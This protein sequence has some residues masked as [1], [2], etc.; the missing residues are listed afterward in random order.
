MKRNTDWEDLR[1][2][3]AV[4]KAGGLAGAAEKTGVSAA[5]LG[6]RV[7]ALE[8][9]LN[10][11]LVEREARGYRLTAAGRDLLLHLEDMDQAARSIATW[12]ESGRVRRRIRISAGDWT[13]RLLIDNIAGFWSP[14]SDWVPEFLVDLRNRDV[15]RRQID[16]GVRN[17]RPKQ[18]WLAGQKVGQVEHAA[19]QAKDVPPGGEPGWIG[20]VEDEAH[21]PT[22]L[23]LKEN[24]GEEVDITVNN[25]TLA[26][27][28]VRK[29]YART[30]LPTFVGDAYPDLVRI[31]DP[32][33]SLRTERWLVMHQD[34]RHEPAV[35]HAVSALA[36]MLKQDPLL[37][38]DG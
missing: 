27:S 23:W 35:R 5:T 11:R 19:Y 8:K 24:H 21:F 16:I 15:A 3:L 17:D 32:I 20:L 14:G 37:S 30:L 22:G 4:A 10:V 36:R 31:T 33:E 38:P 1:L 9:S 28:L 18:A 7:S 12:R 25:A 29:G 2:F 26:L 34:E 13:T 6:R